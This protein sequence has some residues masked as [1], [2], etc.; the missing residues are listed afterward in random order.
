MSHV[1]LFFFFFSACA[2]NT[3][4]GFS[5]NELRIVMLGRTGS[6]KSATANSILGKKHFRSMVSGSSVTAN[7][8]R[9]ESTRDDRLILVVDTPG[10]FDT[11]RLNFEV[12]KE[13]AKCVGMT[14]PGPH[15]VLLVIGIGRFTKEEQDTVDH[16]IQHFGSE[17]VNYMMIVFTREDDLLKEN[18]SI[19]DFVRE[20]PSEL[21]EL[22][23]KCGNRYIA[24]N[25]DASDSEIKRKVDELITNIDT[26]VKRNDGVC[27]TNE[28]FLEAEAVLERRMQQ[29]RAEFEQE[30]QSKR[31]TLERM[32]SKD[33]ENSIDGLRKERDQLENRI[34]RMQYDSDSTQK[35]KHLLQLEIA[36][37]HKQRDTSLGGADSERNRALTSR[38]AELRRREVVLSQ[39][40]QQE[41]RQRLMLT[42]NLEKTKYSIHKGRQSGVSRP[43]SCCVAIDNKTVR[44]KARDEVENTN[45]NVFSELLESLKQVGK[46]FLGKA[47]KFFTKLF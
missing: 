39:K 21:R 4:C 40:L 17:V 20:A 42:S 22:V 47:I 27:Y 8:S 13:I 18:K 1:S 43:P 24:I 36:K 31:Q 6:G 30:E 23:H 2:S 35:E 34:K 7:S 37:L 12:T 46:N 16:F 19:E 3:A 5:D 45:S 44:Q 25:N 28:M 33:F 11:N 15:A 9:G 38:I 29:I 26:M 14:S 10:L 32:I 41:E